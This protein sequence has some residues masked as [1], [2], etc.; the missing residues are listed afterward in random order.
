ME[1][2]LPQF[3]AGQ[4]RLANILKQECH[5]QG[6][7]QNSSSPTTAVAAL[8]NHPI[9]RTSANIP[10]FHSKP[11]PMAQVRPNEPSRPALL[12]CI[13]KFSSYLFIYTTGNRT[14]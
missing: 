3:Q 12:Q 2:W 1:A 5:N 14:L 4:K 6:K 7:S 8:R 9:K 13:L 11:E 10:N